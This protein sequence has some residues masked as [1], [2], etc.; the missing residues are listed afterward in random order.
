MQEDLVETKKI[1][2]DKF[3]VLKE[4]STENE[5]VR[6]QVEAGKQALRNTKFL[7][8]DHIFKEIKKLKHHLLMLQ[9]ERDLIGTCL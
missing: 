4:T 1:L 7:L 6:M 9:D 8:W 2:A 3:K 5:N